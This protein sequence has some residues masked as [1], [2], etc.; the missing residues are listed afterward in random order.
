MKLKI[1]TSGSTTLLEQEVEELYKHFTVSKVVYETSVVH[2]QLYYT[3]F[4]EYVEHDKI[5]LVEDLNLSHRSFW[6]L[7]RNNINTI[8]QL[9]EVILDGRIKYFRN[10][11]PIS[12]KEIEDRLYEL[13]KGE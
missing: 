4:V 9:K 2:N 6:C 3:A 11:G 10:L 1:L 5:T 8:D 7:K 13:S 12:I